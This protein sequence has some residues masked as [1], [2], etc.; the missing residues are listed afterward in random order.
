M[1]MTTSE[2]A[3]QNGASSPLVK[4]THLSRIQKS[5]ER[6]RTADLTSLRVNCSY[7]TSNEV[8]EQFRCM[9][10]LDLRMHEDRGSSHRTSR[11]DSINSSFAVSLAS[12]APCVGTVLGVPASGGGVGNQA[13]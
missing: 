11:I 5:D 2:K 1:M 9:A 10:R 12:V 3:I 13:V 7:W 8:Y 6:T 4:S